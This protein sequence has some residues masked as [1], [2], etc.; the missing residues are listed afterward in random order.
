M[1]I[2]KFLSEG[3]GQIDELYYS[4]LN[5]VLDHA[6]HLR[7]RNSLKLEAYEKGSFQPETCSCI[8]QIAFPTPHVSWEK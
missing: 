7:L 4:S 8:D 6:S 1:N 2:S 5:H 3:M